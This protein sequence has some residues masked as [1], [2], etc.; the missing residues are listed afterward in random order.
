MTN[1]SEV[2]KGTDHTETPIERGKHKGASIQH[3]RKT[4]ADAQGRKY[5]KRGCFW[6]FPNDRRVLVKSER[7]REQEAVLEQRL[8]LEPLTSSQTAPR[9]AGCARATL[10]G[11]TSDD[12]CHGSQLQNPP[13]TV[14]LRCWKGGIVFGVWE[15]RV[16]SNCIADLKH[17][18]PSR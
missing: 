9:C 1:V 3:N 14:F 12:R 16:T 13:L 10:K 15:L 17:K 7:G 5:Q 6:R 8:R 2:V 4:I 18:M 11:N